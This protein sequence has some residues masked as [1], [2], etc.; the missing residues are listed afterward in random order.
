MCTSVRLARGTML[1]L[2]TRTT[3][4][5]R[6]TFPRIPF[7]GCTQLEGHR[8]IL[9]WHMEGRHEA[10]LIHVTIY[11]LIICHK[12]TTNTTLCELGSS[13][14]F[15][16]YWTNWV[17]LGNWGRE[18]LLHKPMPLTNVRDYEN[19]EGIQSIL[20]GP[21]SC[22]WVPLPNTLHFAPFSLLNC[23]PYW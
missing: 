7:L 21:S 23:L 19:I 3:R 15:C 20:M 6:T 10:M 13:V 8:E 14:G 9:V 17:S 22:L 4:L 18:Q 11:R 12:A 16:D 2:C 5:G 1:A